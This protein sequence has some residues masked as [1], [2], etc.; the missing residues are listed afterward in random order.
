LISPEDTIQFGE[1]GLAHA[2]C[3]RLRDLSP[4]ERALLI[5][6]CFDHAVATCP[7]CG[8]DFRQTELASDRL[9]KRAHLCPR[10]GVDLTER[11]CEH[12]YCC[13][14]LPGE[15]R[16]RSWEARA[17]ARWLVKHSRE[18]SDNA[19]VLMREAEAAIASLR[20]TIRRLASGG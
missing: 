10:C 4:E 9:G 3:Q 8:E 15:V 7:K 12:L 5:R 13:A 2:D 19:D 18:L 20:E 14:M 11:L 16:R 17:T 6:Y 1:D